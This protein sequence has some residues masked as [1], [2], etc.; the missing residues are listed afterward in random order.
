MR[1]L[2]SRRSLIWS[3]S[4]RRR[5]SDVSI[6]SVAKAGTVADAVASLYVH[7]EPIDEGLI[8]GGV[9]RRGYEADW[10]WFSAANPADRVSGTEICT[11][12]SPW[13]GVDSD[14]Y[15]PDRK[16]RKARGPT[17]WLHV[18][19]NA[20]TLRR[21]S[22]PGVLRALLPRKLGPVSQLRV[23]PTHGGRC[24]GRDGCICRAGEAQARR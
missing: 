22:R 11:G 14:T 10:R 3:G 17:A 15:G 6:G 5:N 4:T 12:R 20:R 18:A 24:G 23:P 21:R 7:A 19:W 8:V 2:G 13:G 9:L 1:L 16:R